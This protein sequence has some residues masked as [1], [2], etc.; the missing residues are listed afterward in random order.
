MRS[1]AQVRSSLATYDLG[2][3]RWR[4]N[5]NL[6]VHVDGSS[7]YFAARPGI[8]LQ[9][10]V[11]G[12]GMGGY[13]QASRLLNYSTGEVFFV[14]GLGADNAQQFLYPTAAV[15]DALRG[16][17]ASSQAILSNDG[18]VAIPVDT[19]GG[20]VVY[21]GV[22]DYAVVPGTGDGSV[23]FLP[24]DDRNGDGVNDYEIVYPDGQRQVLY[25]L[26]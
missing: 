19:S 10:P 6:H 25:Q 14:Y 20:K 1:L 5:G 18:L 22:L 23:A 8:L 13:S 15:P 17:S 16:L 21:Q 3:V 12:L 4:R 9:T 24:I 7:S 26:P 2:D 11:N